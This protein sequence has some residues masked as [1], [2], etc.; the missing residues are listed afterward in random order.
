M[1]RGLPAD[2]AP[3][4]AR[5][6]ARPRLSRRRRNRHHLPAQRATRLLQGC[7]TRP[8]LSLLTHPLGNFKQFYAT[9]SERA[10]NQK[11]EYEAQLQYR[12][13]LQAFIDRWRYNANRAAQAQSKIKIL[14]KLPELEL[15]EE[16]DVVKFKSVFLLAVDRADGTR[17]V[18]TEKISPPLLQLSD[19][20]FS[21][22]K[23]K[24]ILGGISIDVGLDS[25]LGI[26]GPN[27]A[28]KSTLFVFRLLRASAHS[29]QT[30]AT[31]RRAA[32]DDRTAEQERSFEDRLFVVSL[33]RFVLTRTQ[34][35]P[36]TTLTRSISRL[37]RSPSLRRCSPARQSRSIVS[38]WEHSVS[39]C[40]PTC[41]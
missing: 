12:Q 4:A 14:E 27:G 25:R 41:S 1:A 29:C 32:A 39:Q 22:T 38:I 28:G 30:Q 13:H 24:P 9:K 37:T 18:E 10:K 23:D 3:H 16:D 20:S 7:V 21:Y 31:H 34:T 40:V 5:R 36:S 33:D 6:L 2:V 17:F 35:L 15:P 26:I 8:L 19:V 11:R